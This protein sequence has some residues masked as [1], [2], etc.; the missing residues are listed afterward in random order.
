MLVSWAF[1][2]QTLQGLPPEVAEAGEA[3][4]GP[5]AAPPALTGAVRLNPE[6]GATTK[7][8]TGT[9]LAPSRPA[10]RIQAERATAEA[11][12]RFESA[13]GRHVLVSERIGDEGSWEK[14]RWT[15][16]ERAT[17]R[18]LGEV[19]SHLSFA[20]F[21]VRGSILVFETT[22]F[23]RGDHEKPAKLRG[24]S[25]EGGREAWSVPVRETVWR[26]TL[27]P[28][29][30]VREIGIQERW[31]L[32]LRTVLPPGTAGA[33]RASRGGSQRP[34]RGRSQIA[35]G[36]RLWGFGRNVAPEY[37]RGMLRDGSW[38]VGFNS[39]GCGEPSEART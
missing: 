12:P 1:R 17:Q 8:E 27:P 33:R 9:R 5:L 25:L 37:V 14:Y 19:R 23:A 26:G 35:H 31:K 38:S 4:P 34:S 20:P 3:R 13:D 2:P 28:E 21:V 36:V 24:V 18:K 22:P 7:V 29:D 16:L 32:E 6:T 39:F 11:P 10:W 30:R 15:V